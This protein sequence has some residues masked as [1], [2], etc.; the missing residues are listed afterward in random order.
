MIKPLCFIKSVHSRTNLRL[1]TLILQVFRGAK[2][3][4]ILLNI[5]NGHLPQQ[6]HA[7]KVIGLQNKRAR[8]NL[9]ILMIGHFHVLLVDLRPRSLLDIATGLLLICNEF[10]L[11]LYPFLNFLVLIC[12]SWQL[13]QLLLAHHVHAM[14]LGFVGL[15]GLFLFASCSLFFI[16]LLLKQSLTLCLALFLHLPLLL[17]MLPLYLFLLIVQ[18]FE[19]SLKLLLSL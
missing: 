15:L 16:L 2:N 19:L 13:M 18:S 12:N 14:L 7:F 8:I 5:L 11:L 4:I 3:R 6:K 17:L 1:N 9:L 10:Y